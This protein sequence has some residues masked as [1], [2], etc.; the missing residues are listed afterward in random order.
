MP[1]PAPPAAAEP[2]PEPAK[3]RV[4]TI[5]REPDND[6]VI[7]ATIVSGWHVAGRCRKRPRADRRPGFVQWNIRQFTGED[8]LKSRRSRRPT[9]YSWAH[10]ESRPPA[11][12]GQCDGR[13]CDGSF[14]VA[15]RGSEMVFGRGLECD[16]VL[17]FP[18]VSSPACAA[19]AHAVT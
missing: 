2:E 16:Q 3:A 7:D 18:M 11:F 13:P 15:F 12:L 19:I 9:S 10:T 4:I 5:G 1:N 17:S 6:L 8:A 14:L